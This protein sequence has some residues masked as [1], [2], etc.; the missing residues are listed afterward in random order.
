ML[1]INARMHQIW[2]K[3]VEDKPLQ[4]SISSW[5][6]NLPFDTKVKEW[7]AAEERYKQEVQMK[8]IL[9]AVADMFL[10]DQREDH[11]GASVLC[12]DE[13]QVNALVLCPNLVII[14]AEM[15]P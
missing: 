2:K 7:L 9:P 5:I 1:E 13:I 4:S 14:L 11:G 6:M 10:I 12:F 3:Q 8:N 15:L